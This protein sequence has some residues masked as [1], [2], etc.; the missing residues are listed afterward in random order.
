M[1]GYLK[2]G[3]LQ[4]PLQDDLG[5]D[6]TNNDLVDKILKKK[7]SRQRT[8]LWRMVCY[9]KNHQKVSVAAFWWAKGRAVADEEGDV[10]Q[11]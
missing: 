6:T 11:G 2:L 9:W 5:K 4:R 3:D 8:W 10:W 7:N 1:E